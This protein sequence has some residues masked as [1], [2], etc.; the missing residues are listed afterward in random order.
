MTK[1]GRREGS[2]MPVGINEPT[3]G[4]KQW[5]VPYPTS[6]YRTFG[7]STE[8]EEVVVSA[9]GLAVKAKIADGFAKHPRV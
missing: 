7:T 8:A 5:H 9:K 4:R 6:P 3:P 1:G 2:G